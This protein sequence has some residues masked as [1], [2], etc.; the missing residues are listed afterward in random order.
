V[1]K[2]R[3]YTGEKI[4]KEKNMRNN[5]F[6]MF[7]TGGSAL[8]GETDKIVISREMDENGSGEFVKGDNSF[9]R[10]K[11]NAFKQRVLS[12]EMVNPLYQKES[13]RNLQGIVIFLVL[14]ISFFI[15]ACDREHIEPLM[16][17]TEI[18]SVSTTANS[19]IITWKDVGTD[20]KPCSY[21]LYLSK[22]KY[23]NWWD[24]NKEYYQLDDDNPMLFYVGGER[25]D[26]YPN[27]VVNVYETDW[28]YGISVKFDNLEKT[29]VYYV[30]ILVGG[31]GM[32]DISS[33]FKRP[34]FF[35]TK[36]E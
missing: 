32:V 34:F 5:W 30:Y 3:A 10:G 33:S 6:E 16:P 26:K 19:A 2:A 1:G 35:R 36:D 28:I 15:I 14:L 9:V 12:G 20:S 22:P 18:L 25:W 27:E 13:L 7:A 17:T 11:R 23:Q 29:T 4:R 31:D 21:Y 24:N 8:R